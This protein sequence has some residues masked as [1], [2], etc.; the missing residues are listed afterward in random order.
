MTKKIT[1]TMLALMLFLSIRVQAQEP[2]STLSLSGK[3]V[4]DALLE[5]SGGN[6]EITGVSDGEARMEVYIKLNNRTYDASPK[7]EI[8]KRLEE[9]YEYELAVSGGKLTVIVKPRKGFNNWRKSLSVSFK[10]F[11]PKEATATSR[12]SGGN[13]SL[14][15]L[16]GVQNFTTSG[17]NLAI[18]GI[19]AKMKGTTS[20]GNINVENATQDMTLTTSGGDI[21]ATNCSGTI[22]L[23]T[24]GGSITLTDLKGNV[25]ASTS[26]GNIKG[27]SINGELLAHTSGGNIVFK[28]LSGS[29]ETSTSGGNIDVAVKEPGKF[30]RITGSG[31]NVSLEL[32]KHKGLDLRIRGDKIKVGSLSNFDG[33]I[34]DDNVTGKLN[35]GGTEVNVRAG[36]GRVSLLLN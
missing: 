4:K 3:S 31:G 27:S 7:E 35:G 5:T 34:E 21:N 33:T 23:Q 6:I 10:A 29:L 16:A 19:S 30:I 9:D 20:G 22:I 17:G 18:S 14:K 24:S 32:P 15:N 12:T 2:Y 8:K 36:S 13:I 28:E 25:D 26:G 11:L 1:T